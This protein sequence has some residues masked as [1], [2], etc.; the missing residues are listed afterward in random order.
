MV[1]TF[2]R[3]TVGGDRFYDLLARLE[4]DPNTNIDLLEFLYMCLSLGF[5]GRL[6]VENGRAGPASAD[7]QRACPHH[8]RP[9]RR[10]R[11]RPVAAL[12][13]R[14][15]ALQALSA[16][17]P[18]WI[19]VGATAAIMALTFGGFAWALGRQSRPCWSR[20]PP[21]TPARSPTMLRRAPPPPP[22]PPPTGAGRQRRQTGLVPGARN[23]GQGGRG[24]PEGQHADHPHGRG[25][26]VR[27]G[28]G[29]AER[30]VRPDPEPGGRG[31]EG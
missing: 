5:E 16:W 10:G 21:S 29:R 30:G 26:H 24:L 12:E 4:Q 13:R 25:R 3:E 23:Q 6:R 1:G 22:P 19:A 20:S 8:P 15:A 2:H 7:P 31:V 14:S 9:A 11:T 17:R 27:L 18:V 28:L